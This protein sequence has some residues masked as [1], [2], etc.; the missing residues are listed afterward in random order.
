MIIFYCHALVVW[1]FYTGDALVLCR[2]LL[3]SRGCYVVVIS[4]SHARVLYDV[5]L[6]RSIIVYYTVVLY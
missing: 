2:V 1:C 3:H 6:A 5:L 4:D